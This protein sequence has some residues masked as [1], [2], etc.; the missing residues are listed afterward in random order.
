MRKPPAPFLPSSWDR[1]R[2][3]KAS[4][5]P[6]EAKHHSWP[7]VAS[8]VCCQKQSLGQKPFFTLFTWRSSPWKKYDT[9]SQSTEPKTT[10]PTR[11]PTQGLEPRTWLNWPLNVNERHWVKGLVASRSNRCTWDTWD[12]YPSWTI[13]LLWAALASTVSFCPVL[14]PK[15]KYFFF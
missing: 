6:S 1:L 4:K 2:G 5:R 11:T 12:S 8:C 10:Q 7:R 13:C 9:V 15:I 14:L 3:R